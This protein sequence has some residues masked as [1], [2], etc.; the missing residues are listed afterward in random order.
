MRS[1]LR[2]LGT[3]LIVLSLLGLWAVA[4]IGFGPDSTPPPWVAAPVAPRYT[5]P[6]TTTRATS[7]QPGSPQLTTAASESEPFT[8]PITHLTL[9]RIGLDADVVPANLVD[10]DGATT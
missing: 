5:A 10:R 1:A 4:L 8:R 3:L 2:G 7:A 9:E 6:T